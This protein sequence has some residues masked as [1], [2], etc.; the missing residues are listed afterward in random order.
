MNSLS[1]TKTLIKPPVVEIPWCKPVAGMEPDLRSDVEWSAK[2]SSEAPSM[3][4]LV[5]H[6]TQNLLA[7]LVRENPDRKIGFG[8]EGHQEALLRD[9]Q[10]D[11]LS[12]LVEPFVYAG[13]QIVPDYSGNEWHIE[14]AT[15]TT[16][17]FAWKLCRVPGNP[18]IEWGVDGMLIS[19]LHVTRNWAGRLTEESDLPY[20]LRGR[21]MFAKSHTWY[22]Y[23]K[24]PEDK[25]RYSPGMEPKGT[26]FRH[27]EIYS[28][29]VFGQISNRPHSSIRFVSA[30]IAAC[31]W[32]T[33]VE[34]AFGFVPPNRP[35]TPPES[36]HAVDLP[37]VSSKT[38]KYVK[39]MAKR[40]AKKSTGPSWREIESLI[41]ASAK[42]KKTK[43]CS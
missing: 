25:T 8:T 29:G 16:D 2:V 28:A 6:N 30:L 38:E 34:T 13:R 20:M 1:K 15:N 3:P 27:L 21:K 14:G 31:N 5:P 42:I 35:G 43:S 36:S 11:V 10:V 39:T 22:E 18:T 32:A 24:H 7:R 4:W 41:I 26:S 19:L 33:R 17:Q 9:P 37:A 12:G 40:S 23:D